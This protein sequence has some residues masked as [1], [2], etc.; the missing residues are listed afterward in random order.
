[1]CIRDS[2]N[3]HP[4]T[5]L[6]PECLHLIRHRSALGWRATT[7]TLP[8]GGR[9]LAP[10]QPESYPLRQVSDNAKKRY[11]ILAYCLL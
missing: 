1:M 9:V 6:F 11:N 5:K 3:T 2:I 8:F 4:H 10:D 7:L